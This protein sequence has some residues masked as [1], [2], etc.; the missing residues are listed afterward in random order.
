MGESRGERG[1]EAG[2]GDV[3]SINEAI[4]QQHS[5]SEVINASEHS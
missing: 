2:G 4:K 5:L 1:R 3:K